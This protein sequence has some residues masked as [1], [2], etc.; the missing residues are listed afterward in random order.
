MS[1]ILDALKKSEEERRKLEE[2]QRTPYSS[3][4][5]SKIPSRKKK[6]VPAL[7]LSSF[8]LLTVL[9]MGTSWWFVKRPPIEKVSLP[10]APGAETAPAELRAEQSAAQPAAPTELEIVNDRPVPLPAP[11]ISANEPLPKAAALSVED[12]PDKVP[13]L[14]ELPFSTRSMLPEMKFRGH[15][16]SS[17]PEDRMIMIN[18]AVVREGDRVA[19]DL[20]LEEITETGLVMKYRET[21]FQVDPF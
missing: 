2:Q 19:P 14:S 17:T 21:L 13:L 8:M 4:A 12:D 15:A 7:I 6:I 1:Y 9:I 16:Y 18:S 3:V 10:A 20:I 5:G 11:T